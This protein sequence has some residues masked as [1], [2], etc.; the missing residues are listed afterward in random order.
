MRSHGVMGSVGALTR[1]GTV[2]RLGAN[3]GASMVGA[4]A[5]ALAAINAPAEAQQ[6]PQPTCDAAEY[7]QVDFWF[8]EWEVTV[9][10]RPAGQS[11]ISSREKGCL[12]HEQWTSAGGGTGE[13]MNFYDRSDGKWH[14]VWVASNG[15]VLRLSGVLENG[16]LAYA[17][18]GKR[19]DG[20]KVLHRLVFTPNADGTVRQHWTTSTDDGKTWNDAF[21]GLYRKRSAG[22]SGGGGGER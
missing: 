3:A 17:S 13:S 8:G 1:F 7:R 19:P 14:Q 22:T 4:A 21:D 2:L 12:V 9:Q 5:L 16:S 18:E 15:S 20:T 10:G 11:V 6:P